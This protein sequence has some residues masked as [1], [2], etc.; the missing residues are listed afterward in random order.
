M[1]SIARI[2][3][4]HESFADNIL[5][6]NYLRQAMIYSEVISFTFS[7]EGMWSIGWYS[8]LPVMRLSRDSDLV[9]LFDD[10]VELVLR[11]SLASISSALF[12]FDLSRGQ[13]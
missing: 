12:S 3:Y 6:Q 2:T 4:K 10:D 11:I 1:R 8:S 5:D 7:N 9:A 13:C